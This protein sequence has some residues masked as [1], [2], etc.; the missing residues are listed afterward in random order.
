[1]S[2]MHSIGLILV[3]AICFVLSKGASQSRRHPQCQAVTTVIKIS[4][5]VYEQDTKR[6]MFCRGSANV[7]SCEGTCKSRM[8]PKVSSP[9][10]FTKVCKCCRENRLR[11]K[12]VELRKCYTE[13]KVLIPN[14][15]YT[16]DIRE[17]ESCSCST[18]G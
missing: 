14:E 18:C 8:I 15:R 3:Y 11:I 9:L 17:P 12:K 16:V 10:G 4:Q 6:T 1:M 13:D 7:T 2:Y 5:E